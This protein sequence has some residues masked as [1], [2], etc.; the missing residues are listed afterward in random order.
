MSTNSQYKYFSSLPH[1]TMVKVGKFPCFSVLNH[2]F[3]SSSPFYWWFL[4]YL[5]SP[6]LLKLVGPRF[7][8]PSFVLCTMLKSSWSLGLHRYPEG[9]TGF[10]NCIFLR[11][12]W[13]I[14]V[15]VWF[16]FCQLNDTFK[17]IYCISHLAFSLAFHKDKNSGSLI[18]STAKCIIPRIFFQL[19]FCWVLFV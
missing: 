12:F 14:F 19:S 13:Y 7:Y 16:G 8:I 17:A 1:I 2:R 3:I 18:W 5:R 10:R 4:P 6:R 9:E 11:C 15:L